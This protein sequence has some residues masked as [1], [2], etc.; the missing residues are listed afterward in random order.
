MWMWC[1]LGLQPIYISIGVK[2]TDLDGTKL[3]RYLAVVRI[4]ILKALD[5]T[6]FEIYYLF[7][8]F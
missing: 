1:K 2:G 8:K 5:I 6:R 7:I 4:D 3:K